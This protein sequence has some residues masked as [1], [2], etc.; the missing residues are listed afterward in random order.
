MPNTAHCPTVRS[1]KPSVETDTA[2]SPRTKL[3]ELLWRPIHHLSVQL[4]L[5]TQNC[6]DA[7]ALLRSRASAESLCAPICMD[8]M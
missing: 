4:D 8:V 2:Q 1:I 7:Q 5:A 3:E 6:R